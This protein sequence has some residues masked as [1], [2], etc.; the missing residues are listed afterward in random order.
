MAALRK[1]QPDRV[2]MPLRCWKFLAKHY[3]D[4]QD[5]LERNLLAQEEFGI[6][7]WHYSPKPPLPCFNPTERPWRDDIEL[8]VRHEVRGGMDYW[9]R[10]IHTPDGD[11]NDVKR[12]LIIKSGSGSGPEVVEPLVKDIK[13]DLPLLKYMHADP[14][15]YDIQPTLENDR[16]LGER[17][18]T[19]ANNYSPIDCR[20]DV[21]KQGDFLMLYYD[22]KGA[23]RE[24]VTMGAEAMLRET[25]V[26]LEAGIKVIKA[27]WFYA[28]P[29]AGWSPRI[30]EEMFLSHL[31]KHVELVHSYD[32]LY[33][34]YDDGKMGR[35]VD[36]YV[37][38]GIDCLMTL[39]PPPMGDAEP[40]VLK[41]KYGHRICLM[42]GVDVVNEICRGTPESIRR[43]V[44]QRM[45]TYKPGGNYIHDGSNSVP[46]ETPVENVRAW[47]EAAR[48]YGGY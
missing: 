13:R 11:L 2:P 43:V 45:D 3:P 5:P 8:E 37:D 31:L 10:T 36:F 22:D 15:R 27:W 12:A 44:N 6:D 28:S 16:R 42:G 34:Y 29:S 35:F 24:I 46:W 9:H 38:A 40:R 23:F 4:V 20:S 19:F 7:I 25:R 26:A 30:Y 17:G 32:A 47:A 33:V 1:R 18:L 41:E 21:M 39:C 48:E 14:A